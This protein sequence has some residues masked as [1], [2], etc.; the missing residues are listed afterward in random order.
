MSL[1]WLVSSFN[2]YLIGFLLKYFP[3]SIY[4]NGA[5]S[6]L[7]EVAAG[8]CAGFIYSKLGVKKSFFIAFG[9]AAV[10]G[11]GILWYESATNFYNSE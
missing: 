11:F 1:N 7:S 10:G 3:G 2:Y 4:L 9:I 6:S 8:L 5:V